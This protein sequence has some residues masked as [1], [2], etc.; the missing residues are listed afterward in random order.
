M[1]CSD[2]ACRHASRIA[3][4]VSAA[5]TTPMTNGSTRG[6]VPV[7]SANTTSPS[8]GECTGSTAR[9]MPACAIFATIPHSV[10]V[11]SASVIRHTSVVF[12]SGSPRRK[13][14]GSIGRVRISLVEPMKLPSSPRV[15]ASTW[16]SSPITSPNAFT[17]A[18]AVSFAPWGRCCFAMPTPLLTANSRPRSF[19]TAAPVPAPTLPSAGS[20][21]R[22]VASGR[23]LGRAGP[24]RRVAGHQVVDDRAGHE[25]HEPAGRVVSAAV[26]APASAPRRP[27]PRGR[28]RCRPVMQDRVHSRGV[29]DRVQQVDLAR[30]R[31]AAAHVARR[32]R[33]VRRRRA[34]PC[35]PVAACSS[36][37]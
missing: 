12:S 7:A 36:V 35:S 27:P 25:R 33:A 29:R 26:F 10:L 16:P 5:P 13:L 6:A 32:H 23:A 19:P 24:A 18:I 17:T 28:R 15:P 30:A 22:G 31:T 20:S 37:Q 2:V 3:S 4:A 9:A 11:S 1:P 34:R 8:N 14:G 21:R